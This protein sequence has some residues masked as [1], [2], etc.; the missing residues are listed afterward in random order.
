[1]QHRPH[2]QVKICGLKTPEGV[3]AACANGADMIGLVFVSRSPCCVEPD[4]AAYLA[5][6]IP[7]HIQKVGLFE[8]AS[9]EEIAAVTARVPLDMLQLHGRES[10]DF[11]QAARAQTGLRL[12]KAL[13]VAEE[14]DLEAASAFAP[15][16]D[17]FLFDTKTAGGT[18]GGTG[19]S[20]D[21]TVMDGFRSDRPWMLAGGLTPDNVAAAIR[22]AAPDGVDVSSGV[23]TGGRGEKDPARIRAFIEAA[24]AAAP[25]EAG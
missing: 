3:T 17:W 19:Q 14:R 16:V 2:V 9:L 24:R 4:V 1:M 13:P 22:T 20:F 21:W 10:P 11:V 23:E 18:Y 6:Y 12:I 25:A 8:N 15:H 5:Q 7:P